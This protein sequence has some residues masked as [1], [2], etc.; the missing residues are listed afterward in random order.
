MALT[1]V[2]KNTLTRLF[3]MINIQNTETKEYNSLTNIRSNYSTYNKLDLIL[4]E[5]DFL[6][7]EALNILNNHEFNNDLN[8][9]KCNF[10]KVPGTYYYLYNKEINT[11]TNTNTRENI[12]NKNEKIISL[13]SPEEWNNE[14]FKFITKIYF[15]YDYQFYKVD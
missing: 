2:D 12:E 10:R 14:N 5:I 6:K 1:N 7:F 8:N 9:I 3:D 13:I 4:K 15:D 11:N